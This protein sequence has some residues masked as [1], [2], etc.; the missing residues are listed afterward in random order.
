MFG[1]HGACCLLRFAMENIWFL[2]GFVLRYGGMARIFMDD[3]VPSF[4]L[5]V[6]KTYDMFAAP[7]VASGLARCCVRFGS[8]MICM[9][10]FELAF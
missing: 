5:L 2:A 1:C 6:C 7:C 8:L 4:R 3:G 10:L 9:V